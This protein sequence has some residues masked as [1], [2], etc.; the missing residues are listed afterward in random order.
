L[1]IAR[2]I[3]SAHGGKIR[4]EGRDGKGARL[5]FTVPVGDEEVPADEQS[6]ELAEMAYTDGNDE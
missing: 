2:G 3:V 6:S 4:A 5:V 1:A